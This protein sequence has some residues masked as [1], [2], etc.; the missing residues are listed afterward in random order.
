MIFLSK[1]ILELCPYAMQELCPLYIKG[2]FLKFA[3]TGSVFLAFFPILC[4][5]NL[6]IVFFLNWCE[7]CKFPDVFKHLKGG[8]LFIDT[9]SAKSL[10]N[11]ITHL[12]DAE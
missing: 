12:T 10:L 1:R 3:I 4:H 8:H 9:Y 2:L 11:W 5:N 6:T 7:I